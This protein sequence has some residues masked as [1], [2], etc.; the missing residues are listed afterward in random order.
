[1]PELYSLA[2]VMVNCSP[3]MP[4]VQRTI[5]ESLAMNTP[6]LATNQEGLNHLVRDG[7]NGFIIKPRDATDLA[8]KLARSLALPR[9]DLRATI[10]AEYTLDQMVASTLAVYRGLLG[11]PT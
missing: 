10:P 6:V 8:E 11:E 2:D 4:N 3:V 9:V 5:V 1:M 7:I